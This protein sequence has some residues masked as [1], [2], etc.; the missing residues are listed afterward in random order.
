MQSEQ[1]QQNKFVRYNMI[2]MTI[3]N[4]L[5]FS[6]SFALAEDCPLGVPH[7]P[8]AYGDYDAKDFKPL[9]DESFRSFLDTYKAI[10]GRAFTAE[11]FREDLYNQGFFVHESQEFFKLEIWL[12]CKG[13]KT[14]SFEED[15]L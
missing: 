1:D 15:F 11:V 13:R 4:L 2:K 7:L 5:A 8:K 10:H 6:F 12:V 3:L 14:K 9:N